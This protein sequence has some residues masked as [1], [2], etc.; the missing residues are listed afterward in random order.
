MIK[1]LS[2]HQERVSVE[3]SEVE[4]KAFKMSQYVEIERKQIQ[5]MQDG[6]RVSPLPR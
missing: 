4:L 2:D 6:D 1:K 3:D 5:E